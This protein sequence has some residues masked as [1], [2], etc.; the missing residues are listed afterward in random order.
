MGSYF[1]RVSQVAPCPSPS[2]AL[3]KELK[4]YNAEMQ[5][6]LAKYTHKLPPVGVRGRPRRLCDMPLPCR[7]FLV[8]RLG[9]A[10]YC[11]GAGSVRGRSNP[12]KRVAMRCV[13][14]SGWGL[15]RCRVLLVSTGCADT[16][17]CHGCGGTRQQ[18]QQH[19]PQRLPSVTR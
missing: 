3:A 4:A 19:R 11:G 14:M 16:T 17:R 18:Q 15:R 12:P 8:I 9:T 6:I 2:S 1:P 7:A 5:R 13:G 10:L